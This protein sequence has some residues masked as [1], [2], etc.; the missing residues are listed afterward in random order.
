MCFIFRYDYDTKLAKPRKYFFVSNLTPLW[1]GAMD[2]GVREERASKAVEYLRRNGILNFRGGIPM[3]LLQT[4][5]QWDFPN[6][7]SPYQNLVIIGLHRCGNEDVKEVAK[8][9]AHVWVNSNIRAFHDNKVMFEK[10]HAQ[11]SGQF[12]GGGEY[13]IQ[14][15]FGWSNGCVLELIDIYFRTKTRKYKGGF[16]D[17]PHQTRYVHRSRK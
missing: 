8:Q 5:L 14:A 1:A 3:T 16:D 4:G 6:A 12:G 11:N 9:L 2:K 15:G 17:M 13:Q 7:W 10:Y